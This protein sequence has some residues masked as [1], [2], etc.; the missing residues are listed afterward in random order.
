M[1]ECLPQLQQ[2]E[3]ELLIIKEKIYKSIKM[4]ELKIFHLL[5]NAVYDE[6]ISE[7][8]Y[9]ILDCPSLRHVFFGMCKQ[10][11][12]NQMQ[13]I[14]LIVQFQLKIIRMVFPE[15]SNLIDFFKLYFYLF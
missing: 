4:A 8:Y 12:F 11:F 1:L 3:I 7:S 10:F 6:N 5:R 14:E 13:V 2:L 9:V 15:Y